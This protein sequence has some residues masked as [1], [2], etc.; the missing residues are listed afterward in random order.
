ML[1]LEVR[2]FTFAAPGPDAR[3]GERREVSPQ[4][5][6]AASG[7]EVERARE[8]H[9]LALDRAVLFPLD[10]DFSGEVLYG[11]LLSGLASGLR[12]GAG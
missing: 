8:R 7:V 1:P 6:V 12:G 5:D 3:L 4:P 2:T 10:E 11:D 9:L